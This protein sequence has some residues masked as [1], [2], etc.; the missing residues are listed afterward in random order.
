MQGCK[1]HERTFKDASSNSKEKVIFLDKTLVFEREL[2]QRPSLLSESSHCMK[3]VVLKM[4]LASNVQVYWGL[5][6]C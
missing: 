6:E 3:R 1:G 2:D 4:Y 5:E